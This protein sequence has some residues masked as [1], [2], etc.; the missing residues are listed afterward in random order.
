MLRGKPGSTTLE[1]KMPL[2]SMDPLPTQLPLVMKVTF[3][4][5]ANVHGMTG[6]TLEIKQQPFPTTR[7]SWPEYLAQQEEQAMKWPNGYSKQMA[8]LYSEDL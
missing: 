3:Q 7:K 5:C 2:G 1:P 6:V 8:E 4:I